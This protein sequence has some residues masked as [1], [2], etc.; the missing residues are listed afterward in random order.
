MNVKSKTPYQERSYNIFK[1]FITLTELKLPYA[2]NLKHNKK[3]TK[4]KEA[5]TSLLILCTL[6]VYSQLNRPPGS[7][8]LI[9]QT[10][11]ISV[12]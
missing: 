4:K 12:P 5:N 6:S 7:K 2:C 3:F 1:R 8:Q 10:S 9:K 11:Y